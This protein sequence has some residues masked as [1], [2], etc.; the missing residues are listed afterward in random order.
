MKLFK[1]LVS[2]RKGRN[3][4]QKQRE[5]LRNSEARISVSIL[6]KNQKRDAF[7]RTHPF[8]IKL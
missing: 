3:C 6:C 1:V 7:Q 5:A 8:C 4:T 2:E